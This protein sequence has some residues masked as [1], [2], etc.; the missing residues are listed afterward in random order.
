M[1]NNG[2]IW[3]NAVGALI[4]VFVIFCVVCATCPMSK[5]VDVV[6]TTID[7]INT[8][9]SKQQTVQ[10]IP[11]EHIAPG[12][13]STDVLII[14]SWYVSSFFDHVLKWNAI[15]PDGFVDSSYIDANVGSHL[16]IA[17]RNDTLWL[18][19][20]PESAD[21][22]LVYLYDTDNLTIFD[23]SV[24]KPTG[25]TSCIGAIEHYGGGDNMLM[26]FR[27]ASM[28]DS[29]VYY[30]TSSDNGLSWIGQGDIIVYND[31]CRYDI[32]AWGDSIYFVGYFRGATKK[33]DYLMWNGSDWSSVGDT[34]I[35]EEGSAIY[36]RLFST[37][38]GLDGMH[39]LVWSDTADPSHI[40]HAYWHPDSS[41]WVVGNAYTAGTKIENPSP[42]WT[43]MTHSEYG[44][45]TR[46]YYT[47]STADN[48]YHKL[49]CM[50]WDNDN[51]TW[52]S[53]LQVTGDSTIT[54]LAGCLNVPAGH[55]DRSYILYTC[56]VA[57]GNDY[58]NRFAV[59]RDSTTSEYSPAP[60]VNKIVGKAVLGKSQW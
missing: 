51:Y 56:Y 40:I 28:Q 37:C 5:A 6:E 47:T 13:D 27:D 15:S 23:T 41:D 42:M 35:A 45:I 50:K 60:T 2:N 4:I 57:A 32:D 54:N 1:K 16:H 7:M 48:Q 39:H 55:Q 24:F 44:E 46:L 34:L 30:A 12:A 19:C 25:A 59:I 18:A 53:P 49:Y 29:N 9:G 36:E 33:Y 22:V 58:I 17:R 26:T 14:H 10:G 21:S 20:N 43:A 31:D 38:I 52:G 11:R 8:G 3:G